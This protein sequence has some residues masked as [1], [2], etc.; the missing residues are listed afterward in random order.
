MVELHQMYSAM[1]GSAHNYIKAERAKG[2]MLTQCPQCGRVKHESEIE[3][4][5]GVR[6][7]VGP[8][9]QMACHVRANA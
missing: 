5:D 4:V 3:L 2:N 8:R 1:I 7:C 9:P 6:M